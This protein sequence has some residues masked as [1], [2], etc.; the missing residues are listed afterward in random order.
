M[1]IA[2]RSVA[3]RRCPSGGAGRSA[4]S[5]RRGRSVRALRIRRACWRRSTSTIRIRGDEGVR[6]SATR[7]HTIAFARLQAEADKCVLLCANCHAEVEGR[8]LALR[9]AS[10]VR[11][12][13]RRSESER[14]AIRG[15]S[16]GRCARLLPERLW[17]RV[18]PRELLDTFARV[19]HGL[20][21]ASSST[22][23]APR[24]AP[25][26]SAAQ[27]AISPA[28]ARSDWIAQAP[29]GRRAAATP[30]SSAATATSA[31]RPTTR[32]GRRS[33]P[34]RRPPGSRAPARRRRAPARPCRGRRGRA[35]RSRRRHR[36]RVAEPVDHDRVRRRR[37]QGPGR[38]VAVGRR[39]HPHRLVR[40][41][42]R[43]PPAPGGSRGPG[44][45]T[46]PPAPAAHRR[47]AARRPG[48]A[49]RTAIGPVTCTCGR[50][51]A[52]V[53]ELREGRDQR[54]LLGDP[55][56]KALGRR[57]PDH[58]RATR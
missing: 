6:A 45:S 37:R 17:V 2:A 21:R 14:N 54:E 20:G 58:R 56:V 39:Q 15:S 26:W 29:C 1:P 4:D 19:L 18:P 7:E 13:I 8:R 36:L 52:R 28:R 43:A 24:S 48:T 30:A 22:S 55:A 12:D 16:I 9:T 5:S 11:R 31:R 40:R 44:R 3:R 10:R 25:S 46:A 23:S 27:A 49:A 33:R 38:R 50:P 34:C 41:A 35:T 32:P 42:P 47:R 51:M 53:L 57:Q